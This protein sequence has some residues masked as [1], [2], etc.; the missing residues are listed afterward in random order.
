[1][2]NGAPSMADTAVRDEEPL[3]RLRG[4]RV[5]YPSERGDA[6]AVD[7]LSFD[8]CARETIGIVG[9]SGCGKSSALRAILGLVSPP[10]RVDGGE[11]MWK[12]GVDLLDLPRKGLR[13]IR[14]REIA[15]IFQDP[16]A[17]LDPVFTVGDQLR[18][19]LHR[20][21]GFSRRDARSEAIQLLER[22]HIAAAASRLRD[23]PHQ[24]SGGMRQRVMIA[25][26]IACSPALLL[27]DEPTT[28]LDVTIQ[29]QILGLLAELQ[30]ELGMSIVLV[31]HDLGV[32]AQYADRVVVMYAGR[33]VEA[34]TVSEVL[35]TPRHPYTAAL[36]ASV[37]QMPGE[38]S[39]KRLQAIAGH[40]PN[41][42]SL[43]PGCSFAP[44]CS[45]AQPEC[46]AVDMTLDDSSGGHG[47]ACPVVD[48]RTSTA[49][50]RQET[51][52]GHDD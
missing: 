44:R 52:V 33:V 1:M 23:Y 9:E 14:G 19:V 15:M 49:A 48:V 34:G 45:F 29:D 47:S 3:L 12:G 46:A 16:L 6:V 42:A 25:I 39:S 50:R 27:A 22:V 26:A 10:G 8:L 7:R 30:D 21:G 5:V 31:S 11:A 51:S 35:D 38:G 41:L 13:E 40:P 20:R 43:P 18:E 2:N 28:A 36:L 4:L 37:P 24:L 17:S 32:I